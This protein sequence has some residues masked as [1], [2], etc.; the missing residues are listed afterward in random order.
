MNKENAS[1]P[2][3]AELRNLIAKG[4]IKYAIEILLKNSADFDENFQNVI[5]QLSAQLNNLEKENI[6]GIIPRKNYSVSRNRITH[7]LLELIDSLPESESSLTQERGILK[8]GVIEDRKN[9]F[10][11]AIAEIERVKGDNNGTTLNLS[12]LN[13]TEIPKEV[14][15]LKHI[16]S[17]NLSDNKI[18]EIKNLNKL[19]NLEVLDL[20]NNKISRIEN[21][22]N[23]T[24]LK[25]LLL[26]KNEILE[27]DNLE[28]L[29]QLEFV[30]LNENKITEIKNISSLKKLREIQFSNNPIK[31]IE[32]LEN[33]PRLSRL[34]LNNCEISKIENLEK[35]PKL[36][37]LYLNHNKIKKLENLYELE[38]IIRMDLGYNNI[39]EI[40]ILQGRELSQL[41]KLHLNNNAIT[42]ESINE[43]KSFFDFL[44]N[45]NPHFLLYIDN[46]PFLD[47]IKSLKKSDYPANKNHYSTFLKD[48]LIITYEEKSV[49][50]NLPHKL[51]LIGNSNAGKSSLVNFL[52]TG[53]L[54]D[55]SP[56]K[57]TEV[58][59]IIQ[60]KRKNK[61]EFLIYDFGGQDYYHATYQMFF[62]E[63]AS[64]ILLWSKD[65]NHNFFNREKTDLRP[66]EY[67]CFDINYWL[68]NIQYLNETVSS[69]KSGEQKNKGWYKNLILVENK[70]D[71]AFDEP[72]ALKPDE[73]FGE[74][75]QFKISLWKPKDQPI[76]KT[77]R[78]WLKDFLQSLHQTKSEETKKRKAAIQDY[79]SEW[80]NLK[81][82]KNEWRFNE[83]KKHLQEK[84]K[85]W[86]K[87]D[88]DDF[89]RILNRFSVSGLV[90]W[91]RYV[92]KLENRIWV[93]PNQLQAPILELL[94]HKD[95]KDFQGK[96]PLED[97]NKL[98]EFEHYR[99]L[100]MQKQIITYDEHDQIY[101]VPQKLQLNPEEDP[102]YRIAI[103]GL[104]S[105]FTIKFKN[106]MPLGIM[107][108]LIHMFGKISDKKYYSRYEMVFSLDPER[109]S[110][111]ISDE[112]ILLQCDMESLTLIVSST[113]DSEDLW[114]EIFGRILLTYHRKEEHPNDIS[115]TRIQQQSNIEQN[116][117]ISK[118]HTTSAKLNFDELIPNDLQISLGDEYFVDYSEIKKAVNLNLKKVQ[119]CKSKED[120]KEVRVYHYSPFFSKEIKKPKKVFISYSHDDLDYRK[121]L[122]KYLINME[123]DNLI[124]VWQDG[125]IQP[126]TEWDLAIKENLEKA[127]IIILLVSQSFIASNYIHEVEL[128]KT[129][130]KQLDGTAQFFPILIKNCAYRTW[131]ALPKKVADN[132]ETEGIPLTKFQ[133]IPQSQDELRLKPINSWE[134]PE[135][136]W[137]EINNKLREYV[138]A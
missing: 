25:S 44:E 138:T 104:K 103:Q 115:I 88:D 136:A 55:G 14:N 38:S 62:S 63:D 19:E 87:L 6:Q 122:Q 43:N 72:K 73:R 51:V 83:L 34:F 137:V 50:I 13:L 31:K 32:N 67:Y 123:R 60:W 77:R 58:L 92:K 91:Y 125:M 84:F 56:K 4:E 53:K 28:N 101:I 105:S 12:S 8:K 69:N 17:I 70:I 54:Q 124:E 42:I 107:N 22:G 30:Y 74:I 93:D 128:K 90:I 81:K 21:I 16:V 85:S 99:D 5:F 109:V 135:D 132:L 100:L 7:S 98:P 3:K 97:Y 35:L 27:I 89:S 126:G 10:E 110:S 133:F 23:L 95:L 76:F 2:F 52:R 82:I 46:N 112:K 65:S 127:D 86:E 68:G 71:T 118:S 39:S 116:S 114:K 102:L 40:E 57:S 94:N 48:K 9:N 131:K 59:D 64:Y 117:N 108:R 80:D 26:T 61:P 1:L 129:M 24:K 120:I 119:V 96:I 111:N 29:E 45:K 41:E 106:F 49:E 36:N 121:E 33:L 20:N 78:K 15:E 47:E 75:E 79:L 134:H 113:N 130:E 37:F 66:E 18:I 11:K